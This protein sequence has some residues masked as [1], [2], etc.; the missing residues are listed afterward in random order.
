LIPAGF[1]GDGPEAFAMDPSASG[2]GDLV[3]GKADA[4]SGPL[5]GGPT[6]PPDYAEGVEKGTFW[7]F[8]AWTA[9]TLHLTNKVERPLFR[10]SRPLFRSSHRY[11]RPVPYLPGVLPSSTR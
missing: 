6:V 4:A 8:L 2:T 7:F 3:L 11:S 10:S 1:G 5:W 9:L